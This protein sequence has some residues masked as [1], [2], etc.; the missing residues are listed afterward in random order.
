MPQDGFFL[1]QP[2]HAVQRVPFSDPSSRL[3]ALFEPIAAARHPL[4]DCAR[5]VHQ[6][7]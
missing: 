3:S 1:C 5:H 4:I 6:S 2:Q 7:V